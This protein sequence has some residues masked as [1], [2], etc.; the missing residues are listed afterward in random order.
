[1][2]EEWKGRS[3]GEWLEG[4]HGGTPDGV[5]WF[6]GAEPEVGEGI[7]V[8]CRVRIGHAAE[9]VEDVA[10]GEVM[11]KGHWGGAAGVL[12]GSRAGAATACS[13]WSQGTLDRGVASGSAQRSSGRTVGP[14]VGRPVNKA[15]LL[16]KRGPFSPLLLDNDL[17]VTCTISGMRGTR[18]S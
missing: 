10:G 5:G 1:M 2:G 15:T 16:Q 7:E 18:R 17:S 14:R 8:E 9:G 11:S 12:R 4:E 3:G 13:D 6:R